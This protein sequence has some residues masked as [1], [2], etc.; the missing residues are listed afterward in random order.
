MVRWCQIRCQLIPSLSD[1]S[2][3]LQIQTTQVNHTGE[4]TQIKRW[5][6]HSCSGL[7]QWSFCCKRCYLQCLLHVRHHKKCCLSYQ[8]PKSH[9]R[10]P[11]LVGTATNVAS[12]RVA[13]GSPKLF[14]GC[15]GFYRINKCYQNK[16]RYP[17]DSDLSGGWHRTAEVCSSKA[18]GIPPGSGIEKGGEWRC[19]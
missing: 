15:S 4:L 11:Q 5:V 17:T 16:P 14:E 10:I 13:P 3:Q 7:V 1:Y 12:S 8:A 2:Y 6:I 19:A 18:S 9:P